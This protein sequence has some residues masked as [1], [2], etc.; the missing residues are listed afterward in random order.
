MISQEQRGRKIISKISR[1]HDDSHTGLERNDDRKFAT[2]ENLT[3]MTRLVGRTVTE[4]YTIYDQRDIEG[5]KR[6]FHI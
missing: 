6:L 3:I 4:T 5:S 1:H 2:T